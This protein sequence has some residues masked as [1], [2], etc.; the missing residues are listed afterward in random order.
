MVDVRLSTRPGREC[1]VVEV[2]G[3]LDMATAPQVRDVL[4][5]ILDT[6]T[7]NVVVDLAGVGRSG[8]GARKGVTVL[9]CYG[10]TGSTERRC[11]LATEAGST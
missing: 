5:R 11:V 3:E 6:G 1:T 4:Q 10:V 9:G 2:A 7:R 8:Q